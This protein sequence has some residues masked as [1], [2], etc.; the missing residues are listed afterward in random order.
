MSLKEQENILEQCS[1]FSTD[2]ISEN[3]FS[4]FMTNNR[5]FFERI[6]FK[7]ITNDPIFYRTT[8]AEPEDAKAPEC[9]I[10]L[11]Q[12]SSMFTKQ[13]HCK[14]CGS[15]LCNACS[16]N[17][18]NSKTICEICID[19]FENF[20][21]H[22]NFKQ[23]LIDK[24]LSIKEVSQ[25]IERLSLFNS[26][27]LE[28][29]QKIRNSIDGEK[30]R[31]KTAIEDLNEQIGQVRRSGQES[32][33]ESS[34]MT[35]KINQKIN[36]LKQVDAEKNDLELKYNEKDKQREELYCDIEKANKRLEDLTQSNQELSIAINNF[37]S[38]ETRLNER[39]VID[40]NCVL[41]EYYRMP[42]D[43][44]NKK[45]NA[46]RKLNDQGQSTSSDKQSLIS[47]LG[48]FFIDL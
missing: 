43:L 45:R 4:D 36:E 37:Y 14:Y 30:Q 9:K 11:E 22:Q 7:D 6:G 21:I 26:E 12:L 24:E 28:E 48:S 18:R 34:R 41:K 44:E 16:K 39:I 47:K 20:Q 17:Q 8:D 27:Q 25:K 13:K 42:L 46:S 1:Q 31:F 32:E 15:Y 3:L 29:I 40:T 19:K 5:D 35:E 2:N 38:K 33:G 23:S 10:C